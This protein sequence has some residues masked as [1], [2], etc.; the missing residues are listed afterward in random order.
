MPFVIKFPQGLSI[1][2]EGVLRNNRDIANDLLK[3]IVGG[4]SIITPKGWSIE[5]IGPQLYFMDGDGI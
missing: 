2:S 4:K 1:H 3:D 5:W